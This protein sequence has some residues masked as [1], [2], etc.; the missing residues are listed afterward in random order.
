MAHFK[1]SLSLM[2]ILALTLIFVSCTKPP[3][4]ERS[5]AK[6][7]MDAAVASG[8]DKYATRILDAAKKIWG[9]AEVEMRDK[10]YEEAKQNYVT[11]KVVFDIAAGNAQEG[12]KI[13]A[14][15]A[16]AIITGLEEDWKNLNITARNHEKM[17]KDEQMKNEWVADTRAFTEGLKA[18]KDKIVDDPVSAM[19]NVSEL[20][21]II[22]KWD[23]AFKK[24]AAAQSEQKTIKKKSKITKKKQKAVEKKIKT[25]TKKKK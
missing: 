12:K 6:T 23:I 22:E 3:E 19:T 21:Y 16:N 9:V 2:I 10:K 14:A 15:E 4:A 25:M 24:L 20:K 13:A 5:A 7:A 8:A 18:H 17:M 11:A 1:Q